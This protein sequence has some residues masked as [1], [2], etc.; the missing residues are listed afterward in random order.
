MVRKVITIPKTGLIG[1]NAPKRKPVFKGRQYLPASERKQVYLPS[2]TIA[3]ARTPFLSPR[4][5]QFHVPLNFNKLDMRDY[6]KNLYNVNV[7]KIR[8][9]IEQ[10]P[11]TR[12]TRDGRTLGKWRRPKSEKRMTVELREP[13]IWP[14]EPEDLTKWEKDSW[15]STVKAQHEAQKEGAQ[16]GHAAEEP[17][18]ELRKAYEKQAEELKQDKESWQ[19][20]WK[21]LGLDFA[22]KEFANTR[23]GGFNRPKWISVPKKP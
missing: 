13:F 9:Y 14:E 16:K 3:L 19:P 15:T 10:Q 6:L 5:A 20:T 2:F 23:G 22:N 7:I 1:R 4:Y 11:I 18:K 17:D 21:V 8:S 12:V